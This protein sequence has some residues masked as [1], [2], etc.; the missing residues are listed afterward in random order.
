MVTGR[1]ISGVHWATDIVGAALLSFGLF[2]VYRYGVE[3]WDRRR[4]EKHGI[5]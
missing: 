3:A 1:L 5:Q 4:E 2:F